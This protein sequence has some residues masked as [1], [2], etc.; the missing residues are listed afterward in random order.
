MRR[1]KAEAKKL[2]V[3]IEVSEEMGRHELVSSAQPAHA[4]A[5]APS[6]ARSSGRPAVH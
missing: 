4:R 2:K 5:A 3:K 1:L 6:L